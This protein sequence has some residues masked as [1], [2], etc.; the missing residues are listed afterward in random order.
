MCI[1]GELVAPG[2]RVQCKDLDVPRVPF[3]PWFC[4]PV[5]GE[6]IWQATKTGQKYLARCSSPSWVVLWETNCLLFLIL[7]PCDPG[8]TRFSWNFVVLGQSCHELER[9]QFLAQVSPGN[10]ADPGCPQVLGSTSMHRWPGA[11]ALS[12]SL[13]GQPSTV[14]DDSKANGLRR[15]LGTRRSILHPCVVLWRHRWCC[16]KVAQI[17]EAMQSIEVLHGQVARVSLVLSW[18]V[19]MM[20]LH[21]GFGHEIN[22]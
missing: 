22:I 3:V 20:R 5:W 15:L 12:L 18:S 6:Y 1:I 8:N 9:Y 21:C 11:G 19:S 14:L 2:C 16:W 17:G 10:C 7:D 13:W 4:L